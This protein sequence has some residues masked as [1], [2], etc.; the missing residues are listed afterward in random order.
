MTKS[1]CQTC[2]NGRPEIQGGRL[3]WLNVFCTL[4]AKSVNPQMTGCELYKERKKKM[5][6]KAR[7]KDRNKY[8]TIDGVS[9]QGYW[10]AEIVGVPLTLT[11]KRP[12]KWG[13]KEGLALRVSSSLDKE[14]IVEV[15]QSILV[16]MLNSKKWSNVPYKFQIVVKKSKSGHQY[17]E[18][19]RIDDA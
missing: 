3:N 7:P 19:E 8:K 14:F 6:L 13:N 18:P 16:K 5:N 17:Y 10:V 1:I 11:A 15:T 2:F 12:Y 4:I 9:L